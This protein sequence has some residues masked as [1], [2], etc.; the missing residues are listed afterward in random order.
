ML[1]GTVSVSVAIA[2]EAAKDGALTV[3]FTEEL[4][5][6]VGERVAR[7]PNYSEER[8]PAAKEFYKL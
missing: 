1:C 6:M 8:Y 5:E 2:T 3:A 4:N 7:D